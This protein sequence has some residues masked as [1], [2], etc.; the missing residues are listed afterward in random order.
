[1]ITVVVVDDQDLVRS[2]LIRLLETAPELSVVGEATQGEEAVRIVAGSRPDVVLMDVRMPVL[3]G[4]EATR[5]IRVRTPD[6]RVLVLTTF[7]L[8]EYVYAALQAGAS[9]FL[10]KDARPEE[11]IDAVRRTAAG[12]SLLA[13]SVT[14]TLVHAFARQSLRPDRVLPD[15]TPRERDI[16]L[17]VARG[18][19]NQEIADELVIGHATVKTY[20]S[21]LLMKLGGT[22][23][24]HLVIAAYEASLT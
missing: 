24:V 16:L 19:S 12:E 3:N 1:M 2:G 6:S 5:R 17:A 10:L 14:A 18:L 13:P 9:G 21:R 15:L 7:D 22:D 8:D 23:R 4:I 20:V 11:L